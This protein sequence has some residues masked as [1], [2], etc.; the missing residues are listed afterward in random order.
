MPNQE[1]ALVPAAWHPDD[2]T[3]MCGLCFTRLYPQE[4]VLTY[5]LVVL[6]KWKQEG[7]A[8]AHVMLAPNQN[9]MRVLQSQ[10]DNHHVAQFRSWDPEGEAASDELLRQVARDYRETKGAISSMST[11]AWWDQMAFWRAIAGNPAK[12]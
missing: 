5:D 2:K 8:P 4:T 12:K 7:F 3:R 9:K 11:R 1:T 6:S 10:L